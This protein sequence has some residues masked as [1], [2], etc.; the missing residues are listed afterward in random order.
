MDQNRRTLAIEITGY[1]FEHAEHFP[2]AQQIANVVALVW[3]LMKRYQV[4]ATNLLGHLEVQLNKSDPGKKFMALIRHLI[5][6]K[7]L[8]EDDEQMKSLVFGQFLVQNGDPG[9]AVHKYFKFVRDYLILTTVPRKVFEWEATCNYWLCQGMLAPTAGAVTL[10]G[11]HHPPLASGPLSPG[12]IFL[13]PGNHEGID[14]YQDGYNSRASTSAGEAVQ[15][16]SPGTCLYAGEGGH[17]CHGKTAIF[18]HILP[19]GSQ[20]LSVYGHLGQLGDLSVGR[21][22]PLAHRVGETPGNVPQGGRYMH[23]ALAYGVT[24]DLY[25]NRH[26]TLPLNV[27]PTWIRDRYLSPL[28]YFAKDSSP[29]YRS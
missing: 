26:A 2:P 11:A 20:L 19:N 18:Q 10:A 21:T 13:D 28:D 23:F 27:G 15:L 5:G 9:L 4:Q 25:L 12:R 3:A 1:D 6:I 16:I 7:A 22:Y 14:L 29:I 24:W 8:V 17:T